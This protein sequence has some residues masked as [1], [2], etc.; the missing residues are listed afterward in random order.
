MRLRSITSDHGWDLSVG[1]NQVVQVICK[2]LP[3][4]PRC[5]L[6]HYGLQG[7]TARQGLLAFLSNPSWMNN[8]DYS[9][10]IYVMLSRPTKLDDLWIVDVPPRGVFEGFLHEHNPV[11]VKRMR[12]FEEQARV[13]EHTAIDYVRRLSWQGT[14]W[15]AKYLSSE[16]IAT[17]FA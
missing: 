14:P 13:D 7:I 16:E 9:L 1:G 2:Q 10:A 15:A 6:T 3:L 11:L 5:V 4:A 17:L 8:A 12:E